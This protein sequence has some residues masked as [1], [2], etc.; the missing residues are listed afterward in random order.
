MAKVDMKKELKELYFPPKK[1]VMVD[2]PEMNFLMVDGGGDPNTSQEYKD[3]IEVLY[4]MSYTLKFMIKGENPEHD[5]TVMPLEGLWWAD[6]MSSFLAGEKGEWKW[7]SMIMQPEFVTEKH[8]GE[9]IG[10]VKEK[11]DPIAL[12][13]CRFEAFREGLS[14]Q[15]MHIGPYAEEAP[16]IEKLHAFI[17]EQGHEFDG[18]VQK[19]HEIYLSDP[20]RTAPERLKTV[21]RQPVK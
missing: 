12:P 21:I 18:L 19:H 8:V 5:Y 20:G 2:V 4:T 3:S 9:A 6:D 14:G 11:K 1:P 7:T 13:K 10:Q 17:K 15:I 16:N